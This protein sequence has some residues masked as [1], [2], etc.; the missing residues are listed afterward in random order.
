MAPLEGP[1]ANWLDLCAGPGGKSALLAAI[2]SQREALLTAVEPLQHRAELVRA[3][4]RAIPG[5]HQVLVGDGTKPT[6]PEGSYDRVLADVP[7]SGLGALRRRPEARWRRTPEDVAEL[8]PLQEELLD[9]AITSVRPG[10]V[11][12]YVTCSPHPEE[13]RAVVDA[14]LANAGRRDTR[15]RPGAVPRRTVARGRPGRAAVA[16]PARHGRDVPGADPAVLSRL[17]RVSG[18]SSSNGHDGGVTTTDTRPVRSAQQHQ[19]RRAA[20]AFGIG[21]LFA[22]QSRLNGELGHRLGDGVAAA[23]ISFGTGLV[24]LLIATARGAADPPLARTA[25]GTRSVTPSEGAGGPLRWW[26]CIGG[27][28]GAFLVATQSITV[29]AIG[30]A[31]FTVAVVGRS[32]GQ[33]P[34]RRPPRLRPGRSA[35]VHAAADRRRGASRWSPSYWRCRTSSSHPSGLLLAILPALGGVVTAVQQA[36]QR[37]SRPHRLRRLRT[38]RSRPASST[39][40]VGIRR[41]AGRLRRRP[42]AAR[43]ARTPADRPVAVPRRRLR[44][45]S[46]SAPPPPSSASSAS[47]SSASARSPAS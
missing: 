22:I 42:G 23:L 43:C 29:S 5:D 7:C 34:G 19:I 46:S 1:D 12:A 25:S 9:S 39:S 2:G 26:Q 38:A 4:L 24:I 36:H 18:A 17:D 41:A 8:R 3:N 31:V 44:R 6:W 14:V 40:C 21:M 32:G 10:G 35:G 27:L 20:A 30:V 47:S 11:V 15:G 37:P 16:A 33:Q 13:T 28:A 45:R